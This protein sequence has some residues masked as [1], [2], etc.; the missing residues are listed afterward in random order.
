MLAIAVTVVLL[1]GPFSIVVSSFPSD[2]T[3]NLQIR[4]QCF[5]NGA[6]APTCILGAGPGQAF[7]PNAEITVKTFPTLR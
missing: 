5:S 4:V 7:Q 2:C 6:P 3:F 1:K